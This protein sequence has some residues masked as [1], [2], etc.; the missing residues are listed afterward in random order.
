[1]RFLSRARAVNEGP[2]KTSGTMAYLATTWGQSRTAC[3]DSLGLEHVSVPPRAMYVLSYLN[4]HTFLSYFYCGKK[5]I[6]LI[7]HL[8]H[9]YAYSSV[10]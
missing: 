4:I 9:A 3:R 5:H 7:Y 10:V 6:V 2:G 1:M 8:N